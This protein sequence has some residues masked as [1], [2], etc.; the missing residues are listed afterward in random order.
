MKIRTRITLWYTLLLAV[1][2]GVVLLFLLKAGGKIALSSAENLLRHQTEEMAKEV[3]MDDGELELED[4][5]QSVSKGVQLAVY[6]NS[7]L[8]AG[9]LPQELSAEPP[10]LPGSLREVGTYLVYDLPLSENVVVRGCYSLEMIDDSAGQITRSALAAAPVLL[11][12]AATGGLWITNRAFAPVGAMART[13][14]QI[15]TGSDLTRRI[16]LPNAGDE[17]SA[18]SAAFDGMMERLERAFA[19]E[20]QFSSDVSHELRTPVAVIQSQ[21]EYALAA[22]D[23]A[24]VRGAL[25]E[26]QSKTIDMAA[27]ISHLLE[28]SRAESRAAGIRLEPVE[29]SELAE[30]VAEELGMQADEKGISLTVNAPEGIEVL[31]EQTLLTRLLLNLTSNAVKYTPAGG[32]VELSVSGGSAAGVELCVRDNGIGMEKEHLERIFH[33][34]YRVD[35]SRYRGEQVASEGY[36]LGLAFCKW[37]AQVHHAEINVQSTPGKGSSFTVKFPPADT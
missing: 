1:L 3:E 5:F 12:I 7:T 4:D 37:I 32:H 19:A 31:G 34:F 21:C 35:T 15:G 36:G 10:F 13:A 18:L 28:L 9:Q 20:R 11:L 8:V 22:E 17:I 26:I 2:L 24:A 30:M 16:A 14:S 6:Q 29:L 27:L 23:S 33:R 25:L